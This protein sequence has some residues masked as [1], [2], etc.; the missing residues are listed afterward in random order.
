MKEQFKKE[1]YSIDYK[2]AQVF[3][4]LVFD[5]GKGGGGIY[6]VDSIMIQSI[7]ELHKKY[8][9]LF[10]SIIKCWIYKLIVFL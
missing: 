2:S 8:I 7:Y 10:Y 6:H 3:I 9:I 1:K 5:I 4:H